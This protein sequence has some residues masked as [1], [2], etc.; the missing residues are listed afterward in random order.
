MPSRLYV[1]APQADGTHVLA[2]RMDWADG[3]GEFRYAPDWL[4]AQDSYALDPRNLPLQEGPLLA[5]VNGGVHGVFADAGPDA[6]GSKLLE[7]QRGHVPTSP[8]DVLRVTNG[9]GTGALLF[10]QSRE[11]PAPTRQLLPMTTLPEIEAAAR[12]VASGETVA[13][14]VF[15]LLLEGG[16]S[17]GG[18]RPKAN[19]QWNDAAWI[20]KFSKPD[21][22]L[23]LPRLEWAC[24]RLAR[25]AG[26][27]VP[28]HQ[29][30]EVNGRAVLL[31]RR[32][33][34]E[35]ARALHYLSL[36]ALLSMGRMSAADFVAPQGLCTYGGLSS[37]CR[38]IGVE[39]AGRTLLQRLVFNLAI[40]NTDDHL[41]NHG[42]LFDG[43]S[44]RFA[45]AFDLVA[46]GGPVHA[47]G[48]GEAG[49]QATLE[50]ALSDLPRFGVSMPDAQEM[51]AQVAQSMADAPARLREAGLSDAH[52]EMAMRRMKP[53]PKADDLECSVPA[54]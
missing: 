6:W 51:V 31:V 43:G 22:A 52:V 25:D 44:W 46:L 42:L 49:R 32:F 48:L 8:L 23:D 15:H 21:D 36:H 7:L 5:T 54:P 12:S 37:L 1:F 10:S 45:P 19:V 30:Q 40:G 29:L 53:F 33:D 18:A 13:D 4:A 16:S 35:G 27:T 26:I 41:R 24:L 20:A 47:I 14:P 11:R 38:H 3:A 34:R 28:D 17:L 50:N 2:G 9:C 39:G